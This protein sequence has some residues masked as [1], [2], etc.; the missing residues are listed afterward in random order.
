MSQQGGYLDAGQAACRLGVTRQRVYQ[1]VEEGRLPAVREG[2]KV[3]VLA[4]AVEALAAER[5]RHVR[6]VLARMQAAAARE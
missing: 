5:E 2:R 6:A 1:L 4:D 3:L